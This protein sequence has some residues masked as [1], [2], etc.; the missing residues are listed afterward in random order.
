MTTPMPDLKPVRTGSEMKFAMKPSRSN[1]PSAS[2]T[3]TSTD[4]VA[5]ATIRAAGS[6][7]GAERA[8]CEAVRMA[9]VVVVLTLS[10]RDVPSSA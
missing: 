8:S 9:M 2:R 3:P 6:P 1:E 7:P 10:G 4:S 5:A